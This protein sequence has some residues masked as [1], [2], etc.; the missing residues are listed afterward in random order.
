MDVYDRINA[1][2]AA[3]RP[4]LA[5]CPVLVCTN[6]GIPIPVQSSPSSVALCGVCGHEC[7]LELVEPEGGA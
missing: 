7:T 1:E 2:R 5:T 3:Q 6:G 4:G